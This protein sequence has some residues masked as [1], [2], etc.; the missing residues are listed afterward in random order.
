MTSSKQH[1]AP[2]S[3]ATRSPG[4][5]H[6]SSKSPVRGGTSLTSVGGRTGCAA[7]GVPVTVMLSTRSS[8]SPTP[9]SPAIAPEYV[10]FHL[11]CSRQWA[12]GC[13]P[14]H[15][16]G[17]VYRSICDVGHGRSVARQPV[18]RQSRRSDSLCLRLMKCSARI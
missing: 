15:T 14:L 7:Q 13:R 6:R 5:D 3:S 18:N 12:E 9:S 4:A 16:D 2:S 17:L 10:Q 11:V 1:A 8:L